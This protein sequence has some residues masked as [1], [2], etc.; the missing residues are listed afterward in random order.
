MIRTLIISEKDLT[1]EEGEELRR[2]LPSDL[3]GRLANGRCKLTGA[4]GHH[5]VLEM[6]KRGELE[7]IVTNTHASTCA[8]LTGEAGS[9]NRGRVF[10]VAQL[11]RW[12]AGDRNGI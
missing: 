7:V 11:G 12:V 8:A 3:V 2:L 5:A 4:P 6:V 1:S 9:F 10:N